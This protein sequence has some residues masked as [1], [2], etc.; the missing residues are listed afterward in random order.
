MTNKDKTYITRYVGNQRVQIDPQT[1][2]VRPL[3]PEEARKLAEGLKELANQSTEGLQ[4]VHHPD[5]SVSIDLQDRFQ[6]VALAKKEADGTVS[7]SCVDNPQ[8]GAAFFEIDPK[9]VGAPTKAVSGTSSK[10]QPNK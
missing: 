7:Q 5:G 2:Q 9:L 6:N 4:Q 1:G 3:T 8:S 10:A